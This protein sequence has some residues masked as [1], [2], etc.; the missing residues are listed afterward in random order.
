MVLEGIAT[1][2][3]S[4]KIG[5]EMPVTTSVEVDWYVAITGANVAVP[6]TEPVQ[7]APS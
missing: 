1:D 7:L 2:I 3:L 4:R 5:P 6:T